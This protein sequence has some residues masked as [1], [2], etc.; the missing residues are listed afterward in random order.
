MFK[1]KEKQKGGDTMTSSKN[2]QKRI[3]VGLLGTVLVILLSVAI[4]LA[5]LQSHTEEVV[6]TFTL[7]EGV[8]IEL[9]HNTDEN[10]IFIAGKEYDKLAQV[11]VPET[12]TVNTEYVA[13]K[14]EYFVEKQEQD[15]NLTLVQIDN[16]EFLDSYAYIQ[17]YDVSGT[18]TDI[19]GVLK[20]KGTRNDWY[21]E[22]GKIYYYGT[23]DGDGKLR[24]KSVI[25][26]TTITVFDQ[27]KVQEPYNHIYDIAI[28]EP[29]LTK[30]QNEEIVTIKVPSIKKGQLETFHTIVTAY[31]VQGDISTEQAME[32]F[33]FLLNNSN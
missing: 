31:A 10:E 5:Y 1:K 11:I 3:V 22:D 21:T 15:G 30:V 17:S 32:E 6:N 13:V 27:I 33:E 8:D 24:L 20:S 4:T 7:G 26:G 2:S 28:E 25:P 16:Q 19:T 14:I 9:E 12:A 29:T 18:T 23:K